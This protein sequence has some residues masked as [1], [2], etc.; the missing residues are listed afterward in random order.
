[1][2]SRNLSDIEARLAAELG[3]IVQ[4]DTDPITARAAELYG[5]QPWDVTPQLRERCK[6]ITFN[7]RW[8]T[9]IG[10]HHGKPL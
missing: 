8:H 10:I 1:M 5:V 2:T 6:M 7:E 4:A 3:S 9:P